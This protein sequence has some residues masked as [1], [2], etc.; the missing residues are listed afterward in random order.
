MKNI[1]KQSFLLTFI[2]SFILLGACAADA[3]GGVT[4]ISQQA[5]AVK[6]QDPN[7]VLIDIRSQAEVNGGIIPGAVH[8]PITA[9]MKDISLLDGYIGK[10][11]VFY[12]HSGVRAK[13]LTDY[14][15]DIGH[16]S[17]SQLFHLKGDMQAWRASGHPIQSSQ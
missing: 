8:V 9:I 7:T 4:H 17:K 3:D 1:L 11:L 16:P 15:E 14:L 13:R 12:C 6:S 5:L 10:D 2:M